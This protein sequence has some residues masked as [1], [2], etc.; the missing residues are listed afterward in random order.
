MR[1]FGVSRSPIFIPPWI[2]VTLK[3][4]CLSFPN[5]RSFLPS[6]A[7]KSSVS[8]CSVKINSF[9]L[10]S[11]KKPCFTN[12]C[13]RRCNFDSI[14]RCSKSFASLISLPSILISSCKAIG[15]TV[16]T[17]F[18]RSPKIFSCTSS[19]SSSKSSGNLRS[20]NP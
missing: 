8:L 19:G 13:L 1:V 4:H 2:C 9:I 5:G 10:G 3:P 16:A 18:S 15:S 17:T 14:S 12:N 7:R 20:I 11:L 6:P